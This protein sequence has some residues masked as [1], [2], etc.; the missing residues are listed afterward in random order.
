M[1]EYI[2][3][4]P[5][6][7]DCYFADFCEQIPS[8]QAFNRDYTAYCQAFKNKADVVE[9]VRGE[10]ETKPNTGGYEICM[11]CSVCGFQFDNWRHIFD[12][13]PVCGAKMDRKG[14]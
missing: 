4:E 2:E 7:G 9:V 10:W 11:S 3:R 8:V 13:C 5:K 1:P 12:Y 14:D 6:C